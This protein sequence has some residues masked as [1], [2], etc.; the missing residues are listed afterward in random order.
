MSELSLVATLTDNASKTASK[1]AGSVRGIG[2][3]AGRSARGGVAKLGG[4]IRTGLVTGAA[5]GVTALAGL[6][7]AAGG[8][9]HDGLIAQKNLQTELGLTAEEA[10]NTANIATEVWGNNFAGSIE[11]AAS[12]VAVARKELGDLSDNELTRATENA[13][14]LSDTFDL[15]IAESLDAVNSM[16]SNMG[17][18]SDQAFDLITTGMQGGLGASGD[19]LDSVREYSNIFGSAGFS[20]TQMFSIMETGLQ[21][22]VLGSDKIADSIKEMTIRLTEGGEGVSLA[23]EAI[24]QDFDQIQES[25]ASGESNW[26]DYFESIVSGLSSIDDPVK[27]QAAQVAIF[28]TMAEDLGVNF[29]DSLSSMTTNLR[30]VQGATQAL[31][32]RYNNLGDV[33]EGFKRRGLLAIKPLG[34]ILLNLA[35]SILPYVEEALAIVERALEPILWA[36]GGLFESMREGESITQALTQTFTDLGAVFGL[37]EQQINRIVT[38][39]SNFVSSAQAALAPVIEFINNNVQLSDVLTALSIILLSVVLPAIGSVVVAMAPLILAGAALVAGITFLRQAYDEN[40]GGIREKTDQVITFV[41]EKF[42]VFRGWVVSVLVP[43]LEELRVKWVDEVWPQIREALA[44]AWAFIQE[45]WGILRDWIVGTLLPKL[46]ELRVKWVDEVWPQIREA[47][48]IAWAFIQEKWGI[49]RDWIVGTLLPKLEELRV[50]WVDE[51]WPQIREALAIAWEFINDVWGQIN[52][53][54]QS[55]LPDA[56]DKA[57]RKWN[58]VMEGLR[59]KINSVSGPITGFFDAVRGFANWLGSHVFSFN[60]SLPDLPDWAIPG[61]PLPIH[62]AWVNFDKTL[63]QIVRKPRTLSLPQIPIVGDQ[64]SSSPDIIRQAIDRSITHNFYIQQI[65][66]NNQFAENREEDFSLRMSL[67]GVF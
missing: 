58:E 28:G 19:F 21:G 11:E 54:L 66:I 45:K 27:R 29:T 48:A 36:V 26:G 14:R 42:E 44:I 43:K 22:G 23:F 63:N 32:E 47:L 16:M 67:T 35:L 4:A 40:W 15:D 1:I 50:K 39:V 6:G 62:T 53:F 17:I 55:T 30:D 25:V 13:L 49:L 65:T 41:L 18:T 5:I 12:V 51:V 57:K 46:E 24:G 8:V 7:I 20:A 9:A 2:E 33:I 3:S 61:S 34:D 56:L 59:S 10:K 38:A 31:D 60:I 52:T 37:N 64:A